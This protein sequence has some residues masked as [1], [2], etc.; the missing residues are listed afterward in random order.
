MGYKKFSLREEEKI[1]VK[2]CK[3]TKKSTH[4]ITIKTKII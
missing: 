1:S 4:E 3:F 2:L